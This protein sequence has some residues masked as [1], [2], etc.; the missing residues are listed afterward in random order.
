MTRHWLAACEYCQL[1]QTYCGS[2]WARTVHI[3]ILWILTNTHI[4]CLCKMLNSYHYRVYIF[5]G[6]WLIAEPGCENMGHSHMSWWHWRRPR[7]EKRVSLPLQNVLTIQTFFSTDDFP[8]FVC[9]LKH[10]NAFS[11][12]PATSLGFLILC[13]YLNIIVSTL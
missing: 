4:L 6:W 12:A 11:F 3:I 2:L 10:H 1:L 7:A 13:M 5:T 9:I 8:L